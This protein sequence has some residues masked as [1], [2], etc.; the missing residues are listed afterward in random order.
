VNKRTRLFLLLIVSLALWSLPAVYAQ[1][2]VCPAIVSDAL[3]AVDDACSS[4]GRNQA[5]YGNILLDAIPQPGVTQLAF[6]Q[7]GDIVDLGLLEAL[8]LSAMNINAGEWGVALMRLQANLPDTLPGQN[9]TF[10]LFGDVQIENAGEQPLPTL[11]IAATGSINV[12]AGPSTNHAIVSSLST[13]QTL[14]TNGRNDA[15]DWLRVELEDEQTGWVFASLVT[16]DGDVDTLDVVSADDEPGAAYGPMQAFY[17]QSGIGD[18]ACVEAPDSG[19][20]IQT[21]HGAGSVDLLVNEVS[22]RLGSTAYL[23]AQP[24]DYMTVS[25]IEGRARIEALGTAVTAPAGTRVRVP[26]DGDGIASGEPER[27]EAY[28]EAELAALPVGLGVFDP[29]EVAPALTEAEI[30]ELLTPKLVLAATGENVCGTTLSRETEANTTAAGVG[31]RMLASAGLTVTFTA[32]NAR[33]LIPEFEGNLILLLIPAPPGSG[34]QP[35]SATLARAFAR[36]GSSDVLTFTFDEELEF[37]NMV[38]GGRGDTLTITIACEVGAEPEEQLTPRL[39]SA[40]T[41]E[42]ICDTTLS[43]GTESS[44][45]VTAI[46]GEILA[47][48]GLTVTF[49]ASNARILPGNPS[50]SL[51]LLR[52][53]WDSETADPFAEPFADAFARSGDASVLTYTFDEDTAFEA[54]VSGGAGDT[55]TIAITCH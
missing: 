20:L 30:E 49:T 48:A 10:L 44:V 38:N 43:R 29:V 46:G 42:D 27:L 9:V 3:N 24:G 54:W 53:I 13:N 4:T 47:G 51:I 22:I 55:L 19:I 45:V 39:V 15:G 5:C 16:V 26:L 50:G 7:I 40:E 23:Q 31:G 52:P 17:F 12:R 6:D 35:A 2:D 32:G 18:S 28:V 1:D 36:S 14:D 8:R 21:P 25:V 41:G 37:T 11:E 33:S 34:T